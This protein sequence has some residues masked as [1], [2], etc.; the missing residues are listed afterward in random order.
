MRRFC[1]L[2]AMICLIAGA[3]FSA[4]GPADDEWD[5]SGVT[6][7]KL[8]GVSGDVIIRPAEGRTGRVE[9]RKSVV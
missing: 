4:T 7:I 5:L 1:I 8:N 9:D 2:A 6:K 3:V